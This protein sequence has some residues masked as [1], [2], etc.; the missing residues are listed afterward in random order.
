VLK[1]S[2]QRYRELSNSLPEIVFETDITGR[3][4]FFNQRAFEI[5][6]FSPEELKKGMNML[7]FVVPEEQEKARENIAKSMTGENLGTNEYTLLRRNGS[8]FPAL[9][10]TNAIIS[11]TKVKGIRGIVIEITERKQMEN[12]LEQYSKHLEDLIETRTIELKKTQQQLVKSERFAAIGELAGKI[13]HDLHNPLTDI[14]TAIQFLR[15][16]GESLSEMQSQL[17]ETIYTSAIH[18]N[19]IIND[20]LDYSR[21]INLDLKENSPRALILDALDFIKIPEK[22][23]I[24]NNVPDIPYIIVDSDRI[25]RVFKNLIRNGIEAIPKEGSISIN[26]KYAKDIIEISFTDSGIG[27]SQEI[28]PKIFS[29]IVTDKALGRGFGLAICKRIVDA[30]AGTINIETSEGKGSTFTVTLPLKAI[31][32]TKTKLENSYNKDEK[33]VHDCLGLFTCSEPEK[34]NEYRKCLK[35]YLIAETRNE[36]LQL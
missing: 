18:S 36:S 11:E 30:H 10:R 26:C 7:S 12:K 2:E 17:L 15:E 28:L 35:K 8:T 33:S 19:R 20:L 13:G 31:S 24:L 3:I 27:I 23:K 34:C 22:V 21:E 9:V 4:T 1:R 14:K 32:E 6:G 29:P 16:N 25:T 5:T